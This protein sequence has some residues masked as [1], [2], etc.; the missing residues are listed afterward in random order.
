MFGCMSFRASDSKT[1]SLDELWQ[2]YCCLNNK[3]LLK[4]VKFIKELC[5]F[6]IIKSYLN[7]RLKKF[8][9]FFLCLAVCPY[10]CPAWFWPYYRS[11]IKK[12]G[13]SVYLWKY[14]KDFFK[15]LNFSF[16]QNYAIF[17]IFWSLFFLYNIC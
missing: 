16:W 6:S 4:C 14:K 11:C 13:S 9:C 12:F 2:H 10:V 8:L 3:I 1:L 7:H 5:H 15:F 17:S